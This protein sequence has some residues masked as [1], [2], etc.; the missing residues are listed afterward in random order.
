MLGAAAG[1]VDAWT[2]I[3]RDRIGGLGGGPDA[4]NPF[5]RR[6]LAEARYDVDSAFSRLRLDVAE[7]EARAEQRPGEPLP[8]DLR[9]RARF[10]ATL[11]AQRAVKAADELYSAASGRIVFPDHPLHRRYQDLKAGLSH[12]YLSADAPAL[13]YGAALLGRP[14]LDIGI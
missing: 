1:F 7:L 13:A 12:A 10:E 6:R 14:V 2:A 9:A 11:G 3:A 4:D 8:D 5:Q